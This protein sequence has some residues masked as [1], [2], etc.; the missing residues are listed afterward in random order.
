MMVFMAGVG[1]GLGGPQGLDPKWDPLVQRIMIAAAPELARLRDGVTLVGQFRSWTRP[2]LP[3]AA[4]MALL[5]G[6][7]LAWI[8]PGG[9]LEFADPP[10]IAEALVPEPIGFWLEGGNAPTLHELVESLEEDGR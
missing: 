5:F 4:A 1:G 9:V 3:M 6:S 10:H 2:L 7:L 8:G